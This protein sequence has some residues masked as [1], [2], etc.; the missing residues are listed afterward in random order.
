MKIIL[1][2]IT[3]LGIE[4]CARLQDEGHEVIL[5]ERELPRIRYSLDTKD[6]R[7]I[8]G[9]CAAISALQEAGIMEANIL[10]AA[11]ESDEKNLLSCITAH[12]LNSEIR[13]I[14][15]IRTPD[16]SETTGLYYDKFGLSMTIDPEL[17][18]AKDIESLLAYPGF[19]HRERFA[20][21]MTDV[22][23]LDIPEG[24]PL[25]GHP[26]ID[27]P[28]ITGLRALICA[29][30]RNGKAETPGADFVL[31]AHDQVYVTASEKDLKTLLTSFGKRKRTRDVMIIGGGDTSREVIR[32]L[33]SRHYR[34]TVIE[35]S[36]GL[37]EHLASNFQDITVI[38]GDA[39]HLSFLDEQ[40]LAQQD[41]LLCL[42]GSDETNT[43]LGVYGNSLD[44]PEIIIKL[45]DDD[46]QRI[47]GHKTHG[48]I[49]NPRRLCADSIIR[50]VR[51]LEGQSNAAV[52]VR[53]IAGETQIAEFIIGPGA[54]HCG[55][56]LKDIRFK[57]NVLLASINRYGSNILPGA[58]SMFLSGDRVLA[59]Y[60]RDDIKGFNDLF[61]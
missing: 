52:S 40:G 25:C 8:R 46:Y 39:S 27:M 47:F 58:D 38:C 60:S 55:E 7:V 43:I 50:F 1:S 13:T 20:R 61:R 51:S 31:Q 3:T 15:R 42:S 10:I 17:Y 34:L 48:N 6:I 36:R 4:L 29:V 49:I 21:D 54:R 33:R 30:V 11:T 53:T 56:K 57:S 32:R 19:L 5:I 12:D 44:V 26:L 18:A 16:Y 14:A 59:V 35:R 41:A 28:K 9:N 22:M 45:K 2:G 24:H 23:T 37:C